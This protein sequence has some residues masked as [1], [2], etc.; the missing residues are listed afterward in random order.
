M[1][2]VFFWVNRNCCP[3][4][5]CYSSRVLACC[6]I[7]TGTTHSAKVM[8][9]KQTCQYSQLYHCDTHRWK[10]A[11]VLRCGWQQDDQDLTI[12]RWRV[13]EPCCTQSRRCASM[14]LEPSS[15]CSWIGDSLWLSGRWIS[16]LVAEFQNYQLTPD[17]ELRLYS[18][19][20]SPADTF[21]TFAGGMR[22]PR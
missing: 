4:C 2:C 6:V 12:P 13:E 10:W 17:D 9:S 21:W 7:T 18:S 11:Q 19:S 22:F 20:D 3:N 5:V 14:V 16:W 8:E 15:I 1:S